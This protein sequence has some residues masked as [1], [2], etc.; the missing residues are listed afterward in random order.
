MKVITKQVTTTTTFRDVGSGQIFIYNDGEAYMKLDTPYHSHDEYGNEDA[1]WTAVY[2]ETG[3]LCEFDNY[4][5]V[6]IPHKVS[7]IE[8]AY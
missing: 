4:V 7:P 8:V 5:E 2:L 3:E 6:T 1:T